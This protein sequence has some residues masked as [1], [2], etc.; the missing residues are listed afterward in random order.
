MRTPPILVALALAAAASPVALAATPRAACHLI[1]DPAADVEVAGAAAYDDPRIDLLS[2]D[3]GADRRQLTTVV[4]VADLDAAGQ[5]D[6]GLHWR[7][8][9]HVD[10][11]EYHV[12][13][14]R[15]ADGDRFVVR[16]LVVVNP[17][18]ADVVN[19]TELEPVATVAGVFDTVRNEVRVAVPLSVFTGHAMRPGTRLTHLK[20]YGQLDLGSTRDAH[21]PVETS[22]EDKAETDRVLVLGTRTCARPGR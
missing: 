18:D 8:E 5:P 1:T 21:A 3:V 16:R 12:A 6:H 10:D 15:L 14:E 7:L 4:R 13:A 2:A 17:G 9:F 22:I 11:V 20:A 19:L